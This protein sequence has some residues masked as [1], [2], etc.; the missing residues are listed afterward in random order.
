M[1]LFTVQGSC[2]PVRC[3][4]SRSRSPITTGA[5]PEIDCGATS[6]EELE[7]TVT[8]SGCEALDHGPSNYDWA[9]NVLRGQRMN[10]AHQLP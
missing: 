9:S 1:L 6:A 10:S 7:F 3:C 4:V 2:G 8:F 5:T